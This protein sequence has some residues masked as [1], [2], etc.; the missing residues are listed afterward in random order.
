[1][2]YI[3]LVVF[4]FL[5]FM[6]VLFKRIFHFFLFLDNSLDWVWEFIKS[7]YK[8]PYQVYIVTDRSILRFCVKNHKTTCWFCCNRIVIFIHC[9]NIWPFKL[10]HHKNRT[11]DSQL[12]PGTRLSSRTHE[13]RP[14]S[15]IYD[16]KPSD[17]SYFILMYRYAIGI[18]T[19]FVSIEIIGLIFFI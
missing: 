1:M 10:L 6:F 16:Q 15:K 4:I 11:P 3:I 8:S 18:T 2:G 19:N 5:T 12:G 13:L 17:R 7:L 14:S 9:I